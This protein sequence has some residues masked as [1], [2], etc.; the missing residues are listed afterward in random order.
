[1]KALRTVRKTLRRGWKSFQSSFSSLQ[2]AAECGLLSALER[3]RNRIYTTFFS[4]ARENERGC[5]T[6]Q[7]LGIIMER[8]ASVRTNTTDR[9][10]IFCVGC[11]G[12]LVI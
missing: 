11:S 8:M 9:W 10:Q 12:K 7:L 4:R 5:C 3:L 2:A 1:M 6:S